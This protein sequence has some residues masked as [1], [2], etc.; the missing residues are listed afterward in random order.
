MRQHMRVIAITEKA[1]EDSRQEISE[2]AMLRLTIDL[3]RD[4]A[5][6]LIGFDRGPAVVKYRTARADIT[7]LC[8]LHGL[9]R[10]G[11]EI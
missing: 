11:S 8:L 9:Y 6:E 3:A 4:A 7:H 10:S 1:E 5:C 2:S